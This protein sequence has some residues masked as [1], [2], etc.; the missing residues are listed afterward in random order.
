MPG[1]P[2]TDQQAKLYMTLNKTHRRMTAAAMAGF[3]TSTAS[4][5]EK[6]HGCPGRKWPSV[7][8]VR[9]LTRG[10]MQGTFRIHHIRST[11][12]LDLEGNYRDDRPRR[13]C[14][15]YYG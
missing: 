4:R 8:T 9:V 2:I 6:D 14:Q 10:A 3:S 11:G 12:A 5:L 7:A 15:R 1:R 13:R